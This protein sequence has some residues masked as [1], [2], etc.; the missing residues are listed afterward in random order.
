MEKSTIFYAIVTE[1]IAL[2]IIAAIVFAG[3]FLL[4]T[5]N[6]VEQ[7]NITLQQVVSFINANAKPADTTATVPSTTTSK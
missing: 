6:M 7:D 1:V 3:I 4:Q 2:I 5:R